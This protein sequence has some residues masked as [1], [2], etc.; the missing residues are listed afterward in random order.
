MCRAAEGR[1]LSDDA[2]SVPYRFLQAPRIFHSPRAVLLNGL[3]V[4]FHLP[5]QRIRRPMHVETLESRRLLAT[6]VAG[7]GSGLVA[8]YF[9]DQE[10]SNLALTRV[11]PAIDFEWGAS[12]PGGN[13]PADN[14]SARWTG[15][16]QAQFTESYTFHTLSD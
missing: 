11:D 8:N 9:S 4:K 13:V 6:A 1:P 15:K 12:S 7:V 10:L 16:L 3:I 2:N 14:F 5:Q